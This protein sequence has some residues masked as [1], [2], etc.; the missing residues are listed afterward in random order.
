MP[1]DVQPSIQRL[2]FHLASLPIPVLYMM[3]KSISTEDIHTFITRAGACG[4]GRVNKYNSI[5]IPYF[6]RILEWQDSMKA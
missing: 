1:K 4:L 2:Q 3:A 5:E 6:R